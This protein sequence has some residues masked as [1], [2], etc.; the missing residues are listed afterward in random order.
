MQKYITGK[1]I[2][3]SPT[4]VF[5]FIGINAMYTI[6]N[7][8]CTH[9][10]YERAIGTTLCY[11]KWT[12]IRGFIFVHRFIIEHYFISNTVVIIYS[13]TICF[14][15]IFIKLCLILLIY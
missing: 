13:F 4:L 1:Y 10:Q 6:P 14:G 5:N 2:W 8:H 7:F 9:L 11:L 15:V 12:V 3:K